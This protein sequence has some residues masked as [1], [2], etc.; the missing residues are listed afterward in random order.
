MIQ[1]VEISVDTPTN[2][3]LHFRPLQRSIR[4]RFDMMRI[5]EPMARVKAQGWPPIPGQILGIDPSG[6]AFIR[7]VLHE[8][9]HAAIKEKIEKMGMRL[10]P[11]VQTFENIDVPSFLWWARQA[12]ESGVATVVSGKLPEQIHGP[13]RKNFILSEPAM[14]R[15]E[16]MTAALEGQTVAFNRLT[17]A[18][19]QLVSK[20]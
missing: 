5:P 19:L 1:P 4:G 7:E 16:K 9:E 17:D 18:I 12:V 15:D 20:K 6:T 13:V 14:T 2:D 10:E 3:N 8:A 11:P